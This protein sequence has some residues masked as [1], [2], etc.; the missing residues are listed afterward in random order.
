MLKPKLQKHANSPSPV[1]RADNI[2]QIHRFLVENERSA[3]D[4]S[5]TPNQKKSFNKSPQPPQIASKQP[6]FSNELRP[7]LILK[8]DICANDFKELIK[9]MSRPSMVPLADTKKTVQ[10]TVS[11]NTRAI[12]KSQ[13]PEKNAKVAKIVP[14]ND[15]SKSPLPVKAP[16]AVVNPVKKQL[17][18]RREMASP[19]PSICSNRYLPRS[20][21]H[22][23]PK[24]VMDQQE[25]QMH[26][27]YLKDHLRELKDCINLDSSE[28]VTN[29]DCAKAKLH[30]LNDFELR[31]KEFE[32]RKKLKVKKIKEDTNPKFKP[33][34]NQKSALIDKMRIQGIS[35]SAAILIQSPSHSKMHLRADTE[36]ER[37]ASRGHFKN[38][39]SINY[40]I[41]PKTKSAK[42]IDATNSL[43]EKQW[44]PKAADDQQQRKILEQIDEL[45]NTT[46]KLPISKKK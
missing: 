41:R 42:K 15:S 46:F 14:K 40:P 33:Q 43:N 32:K 2:S 16:T 37:S 7:E 19:S 27:R 28:K 12:R 34:I 22:K 11:P 20:R 39:L 10:L 24:P 26:L 44:Q 4:L 31:L 45:M 1:K 36:L 29:R 21:S 35:N 17:Q 9:V 23:S 38:P 5:P 18:E 30:Q 3:K 6:I 13:T 25:E 8:T